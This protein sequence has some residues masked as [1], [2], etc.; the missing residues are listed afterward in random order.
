MPPLG[1]I[2]KYE[3]L[4][5]FSGGMSIVYRAR[6][7]AIGQT[8]AVK[9]LRAEACKDTEARARFLLEART[10]GNI[11]H[12]NTIRVFDF[13]EDEQGRPFM[14]MEF[15]PG[16]DLETLIKQG[17]TGTLADK[18][19]IV[20]QLAR[21]LEHIHSLTPQIIHRD[22]KPA[23]VRVTPSGTVKLMDFGIAKRQDLK[24][25]REGMTA[26]SPHYMAPEQVMGRGITHLVDVYS[27]GALVFELLTGRHLVDAANIEEIIARILHGQHDLTPL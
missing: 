12:D 19:R 10:A 21:A 20:I 6:N 3:L 13:G 4:E 9:V 27:F 17:R 15:L 18:L 23:N 8:V 16:E 11:Y 24:L 22:I 2:G 7:P 1:H 26:G 5:E 25:T 14:V